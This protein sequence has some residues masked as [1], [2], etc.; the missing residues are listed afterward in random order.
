[1]GDILFGLN[2]GHV[3]GPVGRGSEKDIDSVQIQFRMRVAHVQMKI[4]R[5]ENARSKLVITFTV[6]LLQ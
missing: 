2:G 6:S 3:R 5:P 1:M 4:I